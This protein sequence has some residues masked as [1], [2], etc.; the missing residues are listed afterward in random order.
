MLTDVRFSLYTYVEVDFAGGLQ[1][2]GTSR[3]PPYC[4]HLTE[5]GS[6]GAHGLFQKPDGWITPVTQAGAARLLDH[7]PQTHPD[8]VVG[9]K[10]DLG[11]VA[12]HNGREA[13]F[14]L[15]L[16]VAALSFD[17]SRLCA[18]G[19]KLLVLVHVGHHAVELLWRV[20]ARSKRP[21]QQVAKGPG[22]RFHPLPNLLDIS[23]SQ[24][25]IYFNGNPG[26]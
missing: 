7:L 11:G 10:A 26:F 8:F 23:I 2:A 9:D 24:H 6:V 18:P 4:L 12:L 25:R 17:D 14:K 19:N 16:E 3:K 13:N 15:R 22:A 21:H 5:Q 20:P 1:V